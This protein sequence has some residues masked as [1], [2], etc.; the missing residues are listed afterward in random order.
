MLVDEPVVDDPPDLAPLDGPA[1]AQE[2]ELVRQRGH[3][4]TQD[5]C[6]VTD[7][8]FLLG[9]RQ[10]V[11]DPRPRGIG[12]RREQVADSPG[13]VARQGSPKERS[14]RLWMEAVDGTGVLVDL[15]REHLSHRSSLLRILT[16]RYVA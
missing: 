13:A 9:D 5:E 6:D 15:G 7:A 4:N 1:L 3:A 10:E 2:A 11:H 12:E 16:A 14:D 8:Q